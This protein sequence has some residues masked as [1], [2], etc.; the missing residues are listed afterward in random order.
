MNDTVGREARSAAELALREAIGEILPTLPAAEITGNRHLRDLGADSV[1]RIEIILTVT[2]RLGIDE[3]LSAFSA[4][5]DID[6]LIDHLARAR[7][8]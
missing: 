7:R 2:R 4:I 6:H 1:D 5:P 3:P 8:A